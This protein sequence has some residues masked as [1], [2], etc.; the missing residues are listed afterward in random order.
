MTL[1]DVRLHEAFVVVVPDE[2]VELEI[3]DAGI[4]VERPLPQDFPLVDAELGKAFNKD[5]VEIEA[6]DNR[7]QLDFDIGIDLAKVLDFLAEGF[8]AN[9]LA[10]AFP[11]DFHVGLVIQRVDGYSDLRNQVREGADVFEVAAVGDDGDL[12]TVF[13]CGLHDVPELF[14]LQDGFAA[15]D[16]QAEAL[17][18]H[19]GGLDVV[20]DTRDDVF[21]LVRVVPYFALLAPLGKA[22][23]AAVVA[24]FG[25]V[26]VDAHGDGSF[27]VARHN[28]LLLGLGLGDDNACLDEELA[29]VAVVIAAEV[30]K[31][32]RVTR[33][34]GD[35][36]ELGRPVGRMP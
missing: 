31:G 4:A 24:G 23:L 1:Q 29:K 16:V 5:F 30:R 11:S 22:V 34:A 6:V 7:V 32:A 33:R 19:G 20:G 27:G 17:G 15:D 26:P 25:D 13:L 8:E 21:D 14:W 2:G 3:A 10:T 9:G 36:E 35:D 28:G 12:R 18:N